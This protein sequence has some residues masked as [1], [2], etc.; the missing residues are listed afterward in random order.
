[1]KKLIVGAVILLMV[2]GSVLAGGQVWANRLAQKEMENRFAKLDN[3]ADLQSENVSVN[4]F[5][6]AANI[7]GLKITTAEAPAP[8]FIDQIILHN[9]RW[10][11]GNP[12][13]QYFEFKGIRPGGNTAACLPNPTLA[14]LD[15][16]S[17]SWDLKCNYI[18]SPKN[19]TLDVSTLRVEEKTLGTLDVNLRV[20]GMVFQ[21]TPINTN[22]LSMLALKLGLTAKIEKASLIFRNKAFM[23]M[24]MEQA[25]AE[26]NISV[27]QV[28][29][30]LLQAL[31]EQIAHNPKAALV[32]I[33]VEVK[34]FVS[35]P[36]KLTITLN[37]P[38]PFGL[39]E[40]G[41]AKTV[42]EQIRLAGLEIN[43]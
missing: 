42:E 15:P 32:P 20:A 4:M 39:L 10:G 33:L 16:A 11:R 25:A 21:E 14:S 28:K 6:G 27:D 40:I 26:Q 19:Q 41:A 5:T 36:E 37:P 18:Y 31:D 24:I 43:A 34:A 7:T 23:Q 3:L 8:I 30:E 12:N 35:N 2:V 13:T 17:I 1:M 22:Q 38:K 9:F 29:N